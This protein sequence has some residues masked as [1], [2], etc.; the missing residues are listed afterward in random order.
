MKALITF[1]LWRHKSSQQPLT[2]LGL[3]AVSNW[4]RHVKELVLLLKQE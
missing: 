3:L 4:E 2:I 1:R